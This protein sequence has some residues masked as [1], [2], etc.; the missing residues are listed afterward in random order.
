MTK[1]R[2]SWQEFEVATVLAGQAVPLAMVRKAKD[3]FG[4]RR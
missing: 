1:Q 2:S 4:V 3:H